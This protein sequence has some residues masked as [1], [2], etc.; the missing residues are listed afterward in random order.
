MSWHPYERKSR[1]WTIYWDEQ[2]THNNNVST[3]MQLF[4]LTE[5]Y[6]MTREEWGAVQLRL[7]VDLVPADFTIN[8]SQLWSRN[9]PTDAQLRFSH[10][11]D[12]YKLPH[13][14]SQDC[15][16][17]EQPRKREAFFWVMTQ[18]KPNYDAL[19]NVLCHQAVDFENITWITRQPINPFPDQLFEF[20]KV[21]LGWYNKEV[22]ETELNQVVL[23]EAWGL[24]TTNMS[25]LCL[26]IPAYNLSQDD[27][28]QVI[29]RTA[30][31]YNLQIARSSN[32]EKPHRPALVKTLATAP[33]VMVVDG[34]SRLNRGFKK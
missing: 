29:E 22:S 32:A 10:I 15:Y 33:A 16:R 11:H 5:P 23:E 3:V 7:L 17:N 19:E 31:E 25:H 13:L 27:I 14:L 6:C 9:G 20:N 28:W 21:A 34:L 2:S 18:T 26:R 24:F 4:E 30:T 1:L 12:N 8:I